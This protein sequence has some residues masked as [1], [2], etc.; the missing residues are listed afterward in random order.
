MRV[1]HFLNRHWGLD[2]LARRRLKISRL[3]DL[4]DPFELLGYSS[5]DP[6]I[7]AAFNGTKDQMAATT[8]LLCSVGA[9]SRRRCDLSATGSR[10]GL[11]SSRELYR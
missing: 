6:L 7:R 5:R 10:A 8:G 2:D 1:Y 4:N 9:A 11:S 3:N